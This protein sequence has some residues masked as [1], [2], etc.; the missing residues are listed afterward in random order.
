MHILFFFFLLFLFFF[1]VGAFLG[2]KQKEKET[3]I[4]YF[5]PDAISIIEQQYDKTNKM[6]CAQ[7][8]LRSGW[9]S[10]QS[11][12]HSDFFTIGLWVQ[13]TP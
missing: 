5:W 11:E 10:D 4:F 6:K 1:R 3:K 8:R 2:S 7:Q 12:C 13:G 9:A